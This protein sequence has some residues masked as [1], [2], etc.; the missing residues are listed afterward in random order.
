MGYLL[1]KVSG[2]CWRGASKRNPTEQDKKLLGNWG[3]PTLNHPE[4]GQRLL[5]QAAKES[6]ALFPY[7]CKKGTGLQ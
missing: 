7:L 2:E 4:K 6:V 3:S 5:E 1:E